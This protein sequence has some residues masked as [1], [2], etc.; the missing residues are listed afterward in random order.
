MEPAKDPQL[1]KLLREWQVEDAPPALDAW[2]RSIR[3]PRRRFQVAYRML[4]VEACARKSLWAAA[5]VGIAFLVVITQAVPQTLKLISPPAPAPYTV[6]SAYIRYADDGRQTVEMLSTSYTNQDGGEVVL[7]RTIPDH[8]LGTAVG[9]T[10]DAV[11]PFLSRFTLP[12]MVSSKALEKIRQSAPPKAVGVIS[13]CG[14]N[15]CLMLEH[16]SFPRAE[17]GPGAPC[18]AGSGVG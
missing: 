13:G 4:T 18:A 1:S 6:D 12:V 7:E 8:L 15:T 9:R 3:Q 11:L 14:G 5:V 2:V 16:W 10:L 17:N